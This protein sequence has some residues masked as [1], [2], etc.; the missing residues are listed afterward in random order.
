MVK[1]LSWSSAIFVQCVVVSVLYGIAVVVFVQSILVLLEK[2]R[3]GENLNKPL[4]ITAPRLFLFATLVCYPCVAQFYC[5]AHDNSS[6]S[7]ATGIRGYRAFIVYPAGP[8]AYLTLITTSD[9][10]LGQARQISGVAL[11]GQEFLQH[12]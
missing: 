2:R 9:K 3:R 4:L 12:F 11:A 7:S 8:E 1:T 6:M 5:K 10:T